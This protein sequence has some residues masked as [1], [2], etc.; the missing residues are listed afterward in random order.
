MQFRA[1]R[2][3]SVNYLYINSS[4]ARFGHKVDQIGPKWDKGQ[5]WD[6]VSQNVLK[7]DLK[8]SRI[9]HILGYSDHFGSKSDIGD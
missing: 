8:K 3:D 4:V 6:L 7:S 1:K 9:C 5:I 2:V